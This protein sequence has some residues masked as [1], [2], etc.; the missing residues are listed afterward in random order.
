M[1]WDR[2]HLLGLE[3]LTREEIVTVLDLAEHFTRDSQ[4]RRK[5]R[6]NLAGN[7][8]ASAITLSD[9][10]M[11]LIASLD[12]GYRLTSPKGLAPTWD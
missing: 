11:A 7:L 5:K 4:E 10:D 6:A 9:A 1:T 12:R 3:E 8:K 2:P